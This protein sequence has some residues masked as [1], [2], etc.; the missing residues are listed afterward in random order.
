MILHK[1]NCT[2][3]AFWG[4]ELL[5][6]LNGMVMRERIEIPNEVDFLKEFHKGFWLNAK[7]YFKHLDKKG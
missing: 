7:E 6:V 1:G 2:N 5:L 4:K 3:P